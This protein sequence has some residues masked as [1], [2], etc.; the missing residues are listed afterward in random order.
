MDVG[1]STCGTERCFYGMKD[2]IDGMTD[3]S[4]DNVLL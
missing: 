1:E 4:D 2:L 3:T